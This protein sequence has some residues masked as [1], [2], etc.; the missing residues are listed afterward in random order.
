[1]VPTHRPV[2]REE[3]ARR[4]RH[5]QSTPRVEATHPDCGIFPLAERDQEVGQRVCSTVSKR[6]DAQC[7]RQSGVHDSGPRNLPQSDGE[8]QS[9]RGQKL[10]LTTWKIRSLLS[11]ETTHLALHQWTSE[12][13]APGLG[14]SSQSATSHNQH[15][16]THPTHT[17]N[18]HTTNTHTTN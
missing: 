7:H 13:F 17:T 12:T 15:T 9:R 8:T 11:S 2:L 6:T 16:H 10:N 14:S 3:R 1:M 5:C 4:D 18:T